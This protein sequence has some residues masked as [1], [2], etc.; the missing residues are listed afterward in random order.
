MVNSHTIKKV[1]C[2]VRGE[3][4]M[5]RVLQSLKERGIMLESSSEYKIVAL[6]TDLG[7]PDLGL[8]KEMME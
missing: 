7:Q 1:Y 6:S 3:N 4:P 2:L 8:T 5:D